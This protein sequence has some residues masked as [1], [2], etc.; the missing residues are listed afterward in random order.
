MPYCY[1]SL[2]LPTI[3]P[4]WMENTPQKLGAGEMPH[5]EELGILGYLHKWAIPRVEQ[6]RGITRK[7]QRPQ[8]VGNARA[9]ERGLQLP[10][11]SACLPAL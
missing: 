11:L 10:A 9:D 1:D 4:S 8:S 2:T 6:W 5:Q 7:S 3:F